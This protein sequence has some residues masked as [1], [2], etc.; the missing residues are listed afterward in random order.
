MRLR[1]LK[2]EFPALEIHHRAFLLVPREGSRPVFTDYHLAHRQAAAERTGLPFALPRV[3]DPYPLSSWPAQRAALWI[4]KYH[5]ERFDEFD[6]ALFRAFFERNRDIANTEVLS[7]ISGLPE[8]GMAT[9]EEV[10][11]EHGEAIDLGIHSI[12]SVVIGNRVVAG[13]VEYEVYR[14]AIS[15]HG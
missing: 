4:R 3:G 12:P 7:E 15:Q 11:D 13:A 14:A 1:K 6:E 8:L 10:A 2:A 5:P 9:E